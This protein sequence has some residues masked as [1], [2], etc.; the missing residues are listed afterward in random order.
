MSQIN[1]NTI[2]NDSYTV[3]SDGR[4]INLTQ[5]LAQ[6]KTTTS[7]YDDYVKVFEMFI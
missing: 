7:K 3:E 5:T 2:H 1:T 6:I 4:S